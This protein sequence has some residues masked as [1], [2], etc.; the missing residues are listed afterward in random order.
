[1][2]LEIQT[3]KVPGTEIRR[4][5]APRPAFIG[6]LIVCMGAIVLLFLTLILMALINGANNAATVD[7]QIVKHGVWVPF[8]NEQTVVSFWIG[9]AFVALS[10]MTLLYQ[11]YFI[12][13]V[14]IA[15]KRFRKWEDEGVQLHE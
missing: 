11:R 7:P 2:G 9:C 10:F 1:M 8:L 13:H 3:G 5:V 6:F 15:K 4:T 14:T 12:D